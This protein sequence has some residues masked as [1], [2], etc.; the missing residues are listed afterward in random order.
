M[1]G[2][3]RIRTSIGNI[4]ADLQTSRTVLTWA[5]VRALRH[6]AR[7]R[8]D[9]TARL[10]TVSSHAAVTGTACL[11]EPSEDMTSA[12]RGKQMLFHGFARCHRLMAVAVAVFVVSIVTSAGCG[13]AAS[14]ASGSATGG[15]MVIVVR[16]DADGKAVSVRAG[17]RIALILPSSY[18]HVTGSTARGVLRQDGRP[19]LLPRPHSCPDTPGL[20]CVPVRADFTALTDGEAVITARRSACGEALRCKPDQTRFTLIVVVRNQ[21][22]PRGSQAGLAEMLIERDE[23]KVFGWR[24]QGPVGLRAGRQDMG[25]GAGAVQAKRKRTGTAAS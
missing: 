25:A 2:R 21:S 15:P 7:I 22:L 24:P 10:V 5:N 12:R 4:P 19:V 9:H 14:R 11:S 3:S 20:G 8:Y 6:L 17:D 1:S 23:I 16:D 18:W 13:T